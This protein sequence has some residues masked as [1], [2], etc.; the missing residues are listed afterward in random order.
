MKHQVYRA[1]EATLSGSTVKG[2]IDF[3]A[4]FN[5]SPNPYVLLSPDI[6]II[7]MNEAYL[8]VTMRER[9][10]LIG[11]NMFD[12]F[13]GT[14]DERGRANVAQLRD[15]LDRVLQSRAPDYIPLIHYDIARPEG[16]FEERYW[17]ATHTPLLNAAGEV[18]FILQH[19]VDVTELHRLRQAA[20]SA[21]QVPGA[22][23]LIEGDIFRRAQAV[24]KANEM[25]NEERQHL[26]RLFEQAPGFTAV[27]SG[28]DHIFEMA[29]RAYSQVVGHRNIIGQPVQ[30][31]LPEVASQGFIQLLDQVYRTGQPF[32]GRGVRVLL[33]QQPSTPPEERFLDFVYQPILDPQGATVGIFVQGNDITEQKRAEDELRGY[34]EHLEHLVEERTRALEESEAQ[35]RQ[36]QK[37]EAIGQ[38]TGGV[39]HD[40]NNLLAI[41]IGNVELA[42]KRVSD[43]RVDRLLEN[44]L[45]AGE[46]GAKLT[47]QLLAFARKQSLA[48]EP[49]DI[50]QTI[51]GMR[52]LLAR[53]IG[54]SITIET[55]LTSDLWPVE[56]DRNQLEI[57]VLNLAIN[58][59]D[60]MPNGGTLSIS[61]SNARP[62]ELPQDLA[63]GDYVRIAVRDTGIGIP[64]ELRAKV[65]EPFFTTKDIGKGTGLG[66]SQIYGFVKQQGGTVTLESEVG[67]GTEVALY[68]PRTRHEPKADVIKPSLVSA[69]G[70]SAHILV[71]DDDPGVRAFVVESLRNFGFRVSAAEH[72]AA[73][74][75][76]LQ[77]RADVELVV[78]DFAMPVLDGLGFIQGAKSMRP[79]IPIV[80]MTGFAD[81]ERLSD[82][83]VMDVPLVMKP[84]NIEVLLATL[85]D[86]LKTSG[87][88][89]RS[90][91]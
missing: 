57:A 8:R 2:P 22:S 9:A 73:G 23:A 3:E 30:V 85:L 66:L 61:A 6:T 52:D 34:R 59:R 32:V 19:T 36:A 86:N 75:A 67:R 20:R 41:V 69:S 5:A 81:A 43:P 82:E 1:P 40:F 24:Q 55:E 39:A 33:K 79:D 28:P 70:S 90:S 74:L 45:L 64:E 12:A 42:R 51:A 15:S 54:P 88:T 29:N 25:L 60:A 62:Q 26:R 17:S 72:G 58:A 18:A 53:T 83:G 44:A 80:L 87:R 31:A 37:M 16:G 4:L 50:P 76:L 65:F 38:L 91:P 10:D 35:R 84:F 13:P 71:V 46:R 49:T 47:R 21:E 63:E 89:E 14:P 48:L 68:L 78:A 11:R 27:L 56:T 77:K 7:G